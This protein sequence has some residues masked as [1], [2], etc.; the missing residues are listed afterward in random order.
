MKYPS[1]V[2]KVLVKWSE[3]VIDQD[4]AFIGRKIVSNDVRVLVDYIDELMKQNALLK[5]L[6][7]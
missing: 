4:G 1:D 2:E 7:K 5:K 3:P 6:V